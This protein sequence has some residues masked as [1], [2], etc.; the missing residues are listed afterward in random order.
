LRCRRYF[1]LDCDLAD[2]GWWSGLFVKQP[3]IAQPIEGDQIDNIGEV[4]NYAVSVQY[5]YIALDIK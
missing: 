2:Y 4:I 1:A 5:I 3:I